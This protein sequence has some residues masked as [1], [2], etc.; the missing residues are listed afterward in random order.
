M[1]ST[2]S[3]ELISAVVVDKQKPI[4]GRALL[5]HK[6]GINKRILIHDRHLLKRK[7]CLALIT[8]R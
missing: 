8:P 3:K 5:D 7:P 1:V 2:R 4:N 6:I